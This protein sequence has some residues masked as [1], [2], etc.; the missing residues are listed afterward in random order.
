MHVKP[1]SNLIDGSKGGQ[2]VVYDVL[3]LRDGSLYLIYQAKMQLRSLLLM[4]LDALRTIKAVMEKAFQL[5]DGVGVIFRPLVARLFVA[6]LL[7]M[8]WAVGVIGL[9]MLD[10]SPV[11]RSS[12]LPFPPTST[13]D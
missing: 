11:S 9:L 3:R 1:P 6:I 12:R 4:S 13:Y 10:G 8:M 2:A 7:M 5:G